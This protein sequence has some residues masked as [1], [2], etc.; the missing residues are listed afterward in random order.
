MNKSYEQ[1]TPELARKI[2]LQAVKMTSSAQ[3][4]HIGTC[5]SMAEI[6]AVLYGEILNVDPDYPDCPRRDRVVV[7]KGHGAAAIY[8]VLAERGF[9]PHDWLKSF[10]TDGA[11]LAGHIDQ[12]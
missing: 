6:L 7:S 9:F 3:S 2:R 12:S 8:A 5:L 11:R 10:Y 4:S 1:I